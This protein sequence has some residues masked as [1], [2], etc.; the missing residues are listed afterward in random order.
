MEKADIQD[1]I[2][3]AKAGSKLSG[4]IKQHVFC[5]HVTISYEGTV[6]LT[7]QVTTLLLL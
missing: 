6:R 5:D 4:L 7:T 2:E 3:K 1:Y